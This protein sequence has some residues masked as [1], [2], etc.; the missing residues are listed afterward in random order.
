M[1]PLS[2]DRRN[3]GMYKIAICDDDNSYIRELEDMILEGS[4][5]SLSFQFYEYG[6]G[7]EL[8]TSEFDEMDAIFLD[9]RMNRMDGNETAVQ[10][11]ASGYQGVMV[12]CSGIYMPT[13]ETIKISPYRYLLKQDSRDK[14]LSEIKEIVEQMVRRKNCYQIEASYLRKKMYFRV[15]DIVFITHHQKGS[16]LH[17]KR[18]KAMRYRRGQII[19]PY[20]FK[21]L[22]SLLKSADFAIPHNSYMVN[23]RY[24]TYF[25]PEKEFF[26]LEGK[27]FTMSRG[28]KKTFLNDLARYTRKK[29]KEKQI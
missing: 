13:P 17:L 9:I 29:Y 12:Q 18:E 1:A 11:N 25:D 6:S 10:L 8:L 23:L 21:K 14:N 16:V 5:D 15:S 4:D 19:V 26:V 3:I 7:E 27:E 22:Y 24:I 28:K 20:N 2:Y